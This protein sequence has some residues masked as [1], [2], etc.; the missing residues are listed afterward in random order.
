MSFAKSLEPWFAEI[1]AWHGLSGRCAAIRMLDSAFT[2]INDVA[3]E[4]EQV[5]V[6]LANRPSP[7]T[8]PTS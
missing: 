5:L 1:V 8:A 6:D 2:D 7:T 3:D 4:K